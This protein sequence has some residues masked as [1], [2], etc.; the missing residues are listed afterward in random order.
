[1]ATVNIFHTGDM[2]NRLTP[3]KAQRLRELKGSAENTLLLDAGDAI[4]AGNIFYRPGGEPIL[5]LMNLA[6]YDAMAMGNREFHFS[7]QGF[8]AKVGLAEFPVLCANAHAS[9]G[10][11]LPVVPHAIF[12][13]GGIRVAVFGL[14][15]PMI[16]ERTLGKRF[17][18]YRFADP[19]ETAAELVPKLRQEAELVIALT[20]IGIDHDRRL[21]ERVDGIDLIVGG[22]SHTELMEPGSTPIV[23]SGW[24][25]RTVGKAVLAIPGGLESWE[26]LDL[27]ADER[28]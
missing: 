28:R 24:A 20:H 25:A 21:A 10:E 26:P 16:T 17:S 19:V 6:G 14:R 22:H 23:H 4:W 15:V 3:Q 13:R 9:N 1:M 7:R 5:K 2:H 27:A 11:T 18:I 8:R 12:E